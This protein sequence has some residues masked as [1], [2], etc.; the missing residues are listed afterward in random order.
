MSVDIDGHLSKTLSGNQYILT[1]IDWYSGYLEAWPLPDKGANGIA[2]LKFDETF[3]RYGFPLEVVSDNSK[4]I[5]NATLENLL[6][7][8]NILHRKTYV[9]SPNEKKD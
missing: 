9:Y 8:L 2:H 7:N 1:A 6:N 4:E 3:P 5:C